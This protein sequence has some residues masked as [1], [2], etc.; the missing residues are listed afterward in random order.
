MISSNS[1]TKFGFQGAVEKDW[2]HTFNGPGQ[3]L[4][5]KGWWIIEQTILNRFVRQ[6]LT[7]HTLNHVD[8]GEC[9]LFSN[10]KYPRNGFPQPLVPGIHDQAR[11][12]FAMSQRVEGQPL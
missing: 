11:I 12:K 9:L 8:M 4:F 1:H 2:F 5:R 6:G 3:G 7:V 10:V